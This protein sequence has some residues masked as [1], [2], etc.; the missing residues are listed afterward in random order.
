MDDIVPYVMLHY[1][2]EI[3]PTLSENS[4]WSLLHVD[5]L[6]K[7]RSSLPSE[8]SQKISRFRRA[9]INNY[10]TVACQDKGDIFYPLRKFSDDAPHQKCAICSL[11]HGDLQKDLPYPIIT[12]H[13][14]NN[15]RN[16]K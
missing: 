3:F 11:L 15:K 6:G 16:N 8:H 2:E 7:G 5:A 1:E 10:F 9:I 14:D 12:F 13:P 4:I